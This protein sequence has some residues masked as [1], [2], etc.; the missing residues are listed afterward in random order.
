M[1]A[2]ILLP[3]WIGN[4]FFQLFFGDA[5][6]VAYVAHIGGLMGGAF[7]AFVILKFCTSLNED[8]FSCIHPYNE[9]VPMIQILFLIVH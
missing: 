1:P 8:V 6:H 2:I 3:I 4:E 9:P 7:F 5:R